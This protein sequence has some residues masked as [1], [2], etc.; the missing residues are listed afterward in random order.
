M[1]DNAVNHPAH[2]TSS[3][4]R[5]SKCGAQIECID[6][7]QHMGFCVGNAVKYLWRCD[8]KASPLEDLEKSKKY[9]EFEI[10]RRGK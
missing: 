8:L 9:I 4:A 1:S 7:T 6:I 3:P 2:Y 10:E 5:C